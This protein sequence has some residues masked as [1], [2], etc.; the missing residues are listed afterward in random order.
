MNHIGAV[1]KALQIGDLLMSA[2]DAYL[3][4]IKKRGPHSGLA[5]TGPSSVVS[6]S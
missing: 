3:F 4:S 2:Y 6:T 5:E 1:E